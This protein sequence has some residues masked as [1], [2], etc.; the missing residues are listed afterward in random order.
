M[1]RWINLVGYQLV[2]FAAVIGA[3]HAQPLLG[4]AVA[5]LFAAWQL[6]VSKDAKADAF[7]MLL[8]V[9]LGMAI[10][11][12][13]QASSLLQ[14]VS[15]QPGLLAP[16]WILAIWAAFALTLN[17]SLAFL[18]GRTGLAALLGALG[19]PLA[20][21]TAARGFGVVSFTQPA[22]RGLVALAFA[23]ALSMCAFELIRMR[24]ARSEV[25][26]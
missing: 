25:R 7:I 19:A 18:H 17:H 3:A 12:G 21:L 9:A 23:W 6:S 8:A 2:W 16:A 1:A 11:G 13:L 26:R 10:D 22:W 20:Y 24:P 5:V 14:Y 4:V 15:P